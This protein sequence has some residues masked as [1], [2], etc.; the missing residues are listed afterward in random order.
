[1]RAARAGRRVATIL[2]A[3]LAVL[4]ATPTPALAHAELE[5][6]SPADGGTVDAMPRALQLRFTEG[7]TAPAAVTVIGPTGR[8]LTAGDAAA[9]DRVLTQKLASTT[10][11]PGAYSVRFQVMSQD[12]HLVYGTASFTVAGNGP[13]GSAALSD[14]DDAVGQPTVLLLGLALLMLLAVTGAG[15]GRLAREQPGG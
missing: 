6:M 9:L 8:E 14:Q 2:L 5:S 10:D 1:M 13:A 11:G 15:I 12:G 7:I 3:V 4:L